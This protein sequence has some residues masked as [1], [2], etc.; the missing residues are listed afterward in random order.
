LERSETRTKVPVHAHWRPANKTAKRSR[1]I[2]FAD[3][4][5]GIQELLAHLATKQGD[6]VIS[7]SDADLVLSTA[8]TAQPDI[9]VLDISFPT[10]DG[11]DLLRRLK[12]DERSASIP[13]IVWSG[14]NNFASDQLV[15]L[16]LGAEAFIEKTAPEILLLTLERV[17]L[18]SNGAATRGSSPAT[19]GRVKSE[20]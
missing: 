9:I 4:D 19:Q 6:E 16:E 17:L 2:L 3:D 11:R 7:V 15:S 20:V 18:R 12:A 8:I 13:V 10:A 5:Y 14:R 1:K